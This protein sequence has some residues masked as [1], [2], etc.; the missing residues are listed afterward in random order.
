[1]GIARVLPLGVLLV[2]AVTEARQPS[3]L[4]GHVA[5]AE[6]DWSDGTLTAQAGA[7]ADIRMPNPNA[8]RPG[9]ERRAR[10]AAEAKLAAAL[11]QLGLGKPVDAKAVLAAAKVSRTEY[12]SNGGVVLWMSLRFADVVAAKPG[13]RTLCV[14]SMPLT[15]SPVL[16]GGGKSAS[17]AYATY[18][19]GAGCPKDAIG[20]DRD[21]RGRLALPPHKAKEVDSLAG[22]AVVIYLEKPQP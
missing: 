9:A 7:A 16:A 3:S 12:Q 1:M 5:G 22:T 21:A 20:V 17:V 8:A 11:R 15:A 4:M 2:A 19:Q 6:V 10:A 13:V 18:R 14:K